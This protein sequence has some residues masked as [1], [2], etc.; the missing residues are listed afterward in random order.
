MSRDRKQ[1]RSRRATVRRRG[2][3]F[4]DESTDATIRRIR[5]AAVQLVHTRGLRAL[6]F[7]T[8][9]DDLKL[10][11]TA[12][13]YYFGSRDGLLAAIAEHGFNELTSQLRKRREGGDGSERTVKQLAVTYAGYA[14]QHPE[15]YRAMHASDL[16]KAATT[17]ARKQ[18]RTNEGAASKTETWIQRATHSRDSAFVE[19]LIAIHHAQFTGYL[20]K[21]P[22]G[23]IAHLVTSIVDGFLFH[24]FQAQV[25]ID[26]TSTAR[27]AFLERLLD[28]ALVGVCASRQSEQR[29][30]R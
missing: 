4:A 18:T 26:L 8:V 25:A 14:F 20:R 1:A 22:T 24:Y 2:P 11:R 10:T 29:E 15:L 16:W 13:I 21:H 5:D 27:L 23:E 19:F 17:D 9:A 28:Q 12:P 7:T 3:K 6:S 30:K